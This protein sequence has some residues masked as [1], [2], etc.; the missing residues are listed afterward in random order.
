MR[1]E[2]VEWAIALTCIGTIVY[3]V[4]GLLGFW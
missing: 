4:G 1:E 2:I 3:V